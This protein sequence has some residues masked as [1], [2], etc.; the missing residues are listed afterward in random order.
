LMIQVLFSW[1]RRER[2]R[3]RKKMKGGG[4]G[5][6]IYCTCTS[7]IRLVATRRAEKDPVSLIIT[8]Y[9]CC[10]HACTVGWLSG[11]WV[12]YVLLANYK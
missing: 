4:E 2:G 7:W 6:H 8:A 3:E 11:S 1:F 5:K 10:I 12:G 9:A